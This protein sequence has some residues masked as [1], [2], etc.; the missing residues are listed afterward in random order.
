MQMSFVVLMSGLCKPLSNL[1]VGAG[2]GAPT[3]IRGLDLSV[4]PPDLW[5]GERSWR[6]NQSPM[7]N[8]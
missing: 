6:L 8:E 7:A 3:L 2:G 5:G 4:P 1:T